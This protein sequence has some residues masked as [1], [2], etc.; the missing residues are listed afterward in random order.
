MRL[1][2]LAENHPIRIEIEKIFQQVLA[3]VGKQHQNYEE[4]SEAL[5]PYL[6]KIHQ[7]IEKIEG[8]INAFI[9]P[10]CYLVR[11]TNFIEGKPGQGL[12]GWQYLGHGLH[13]SMLV[14]KKPR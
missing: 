10:H 1:K 5:R 4:Y 12:L 9:P 7:H 13:E 6:L 3:V 11:A 2:T 8:A 14:P